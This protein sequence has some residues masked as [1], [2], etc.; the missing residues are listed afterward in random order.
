MSSACKHMTIAHAHS[1]ALHLDGSIVTPRGKPFVGGIDS[2]TT[3][4]SSVSSQYTHEFPWGVPLGFHLVEEHAHHTWEHQHRVTTRTE[5][6]TCNTH[7]TVTGSTH[8]THAH[9]HA[10]AHAYAHA[11]S[12]VVA[13][14][15]S[16]SSLVM[17]PW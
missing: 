11:S 7:C 1:I 6:V 5:S 14:A 10:H 15:L 3:D 9:A 4:P 12:P 13:H 16:E 17:I 8:T 2:Q